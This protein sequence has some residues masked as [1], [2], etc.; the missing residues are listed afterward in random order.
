MTQPPQGRPMQEAFPGQQ[1]EIL[2]LYKKQQNNKHIKKSLLFLWNQNLQYFIK[3]SSIKFLYLREKPT[4]SI[5][6][7]RQAKN[8]AE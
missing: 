3:N 1:S 8:I 2:F 4:V 6:P 5:E 7:D